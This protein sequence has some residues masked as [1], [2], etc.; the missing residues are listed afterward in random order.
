MK[1]KYE[2]IFFDLDRTLWHFDENSKKVL[3]DI[4][5]SFKL[6]EFIS[7]SSDFIDNLQNLVPVFRKWHNNNNLQL[8][9]DVP[10]KKII[11]NVFITS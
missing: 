11:L 1:K 7:S 10:I 5:Y 2:H 8:N 3:I 4:Y 9:I 6:D